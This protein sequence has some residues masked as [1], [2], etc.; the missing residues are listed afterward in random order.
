MNRQAPPQFLQPI[1]RDEF[2]G[3]YVVMC[4]DGTPIEMEWEWDGMGW[5]PLFLSH[6]QFSSDHH[7]TTF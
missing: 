3:L 7:H 1:N 6:N 5:K 2:P 4:R